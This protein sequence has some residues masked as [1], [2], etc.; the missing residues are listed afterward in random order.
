MAQKHPAQNG[1]DEGF[2]RN[3]WYLDEVTGEYLP[4]DSVV[5]DWYDRLRHVDDVDEADADEL[6]ASFVWPIEKSHPDP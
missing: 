6:R 4:E 3:R 2:T 5:R 1:H